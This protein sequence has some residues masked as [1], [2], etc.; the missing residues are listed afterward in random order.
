TRDI[1]WDGREKSVR[2]TRRRCLGDLVLSEAPLADADPEAIKAALIAGLQGEGIGAL[3]WSDEARRLRARLAFVHRL[4]PLRW[5]DVADEALTGDLASWLGPSLDG[6]TRANQVAKVDL[7]AALLGRLSWKDRQA[8]DDLAPTHLQVPSGS[9]IAL[10]YDGEIPVLAVKLQ[11]MFGA[12]VTPKI[13]G[14]RVPVLIHLLSPAGRPVQVTK[15]LAGF[16]ANTYKAVKA[17]LMGR[18]PRHPWPDDPLS[19]PPTRRA[20]PR[21][22]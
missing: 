8:L 15:D 14:G 9:R 2:A 20:K 22:V 19:A 21:S 18:Y 1:A 13:Y 6:T 7:A 12:K 11:E 3:S 5:P 17:D 10:D 4:D 16:W